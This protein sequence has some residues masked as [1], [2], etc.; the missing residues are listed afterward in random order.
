MF[1]QPRHSLLSTLARAITIASVWSASSADVS[2]CS[3]PIP[4]EMPDVPQTAEK[5]DLYLLQTS[6]D[7]NRQ[8]KSDQAEGVGLELR[9]AKSPASKQTTAAP[10]DAAT[11]TGVTKN[12]EGD[13]AIFIA[14]VF[15]NGI[16]MVICVIFFLVARSFY[17]DV[18]EWQLIK[19]LS[20]NAEVSKT[21]WLN[22][23]YRS[24]KVDLDD[25]QNTAGLDQAMLLAFS[26]L[27]MKIM[28]IIGIPMICIMGP[29][30][31]VFGGHAAGE[32]RLSYLSFGN[33]VDDSWL[34]WV[35]CFV[36]W[37]VVFCVQVCVFEAMEDFQKRRV[38]W[39]TELPEIQ[40]NT[41]MVEGIPEE[42]QSDELL[43]AHFEKIWG[44]RKV[45][46]A[47]VVKICPELSAMC[48]QR[49]ILKLA[50]ERSA[51]EESEGKTPKRSVQE[52]ASEIS[53]ITEEI[54]VERK[55]VLSEAVT[56]GKVSSDTGFVTF[57]ERY[58]AEITASSQY[59]HDVTQWVVSQPPPPQAIVW[60]NLEQGEAGKEVKILI[61]YALVACL[62]MCYLP[63]VIRIS[64]IANEINLG[65]LQPVWGAIAP[66]LGLQIM[67]AFLPTF[68]RLI[69]HQC[70]PLP[71]TAE[72]QA[73]L[74]NW[75]FVFQVVF[76]ILVT[77]IGP[78]LWDVMVAI[79]TQP[80]SVFEILG[81]TMPD[82]THFYMNF[83]VL[84]WAAHFS[85][86]TRSVQL[87]KYL[88]FVRLYEPAQ[89]KD[90]AEPEDQDYYG[91]GGRSAR[92]SLVL[93]I[94]LVYCSLCPLV[95]V[96]AG[97]NF[98]ICRIFYGYL[99]VFA[100]KPKP[101]LGGVFWVAQLKH[102]QHILI[103]YVILMVG[104]L[105]QRA[106]NWGPAVVV[107]PALIFLFKSFARFHTAYDWEFLSFSELV[108]HEM[109]ESASTSKHRPATRDTYAQPEL[110]EPKIQ[111]EVGG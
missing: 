33:V 6:L 29:M 82:A 2:D 69:F 105:S 46:S 13:L 108:N 96:L 30:N 56:P 78:S 1:G 83:L 9:D 87:F 74:Q 5:G 21:G 17:P 47:T 34:Y 81:D 55:K 79:A 68:L 45:K 107:T 63:L 85:N 62:Y 44:T 102:I 59:S 99:L 16:T 10:E 51:K 106:E 7:M 37:G 43:K 40:A 111:Q 80:F 14:G 90:M 98:G 76:V 70:F 89:A 28:A 61:G 57:F 3:S 31:W 77:A 71:S 73:M 41:V 95:T 110:S 39:L 72:E 52:I 38:R 49:A 97:I 65:P 32:D 36:V 18:Y 15:S 101:D 60:E 93:S 88:F 27:G 12:E 19:G 67:V 109:K 11:A 25:V 86:L 84:Q 53:A 42:M 48:R 103:I 91:I 92:F 58:D 50:I 54:R 100:E 35:H 104:V 66:T 20:P 23:A 22:W 64:Q 75:Y 4:A 8:N 24:C 94:A 26:L